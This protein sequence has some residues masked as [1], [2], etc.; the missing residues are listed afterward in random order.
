MEPIIGD[1]KLFE[2]DIRFKTTE[3]E[4][5]LETRVLSIVPFLREHFENNERRHPPKL[6]ENEESLVRSVYGPEFQYNSRDMAFWFN[7]VLGLFYME[8]A[9]IFEGKYSK[10]HISETKQAA[11]RQ[12]D[13]DLFRFQ[14]KDAREDEP[15]PSEIHWMNTSEIVATHLP[16]K[17]DPRHAKL[18]LVALLHDYV[19]DTCD[20][21]LIRAFEK[22]DNVYDLFGEEIAKGVGV[23][24]DWFKSIFPY[25]DNAFEHMKGHIGFNET[26]TLIDVVMGNIDINHPDHSQYVKRSV[27]LLKEKLERIKSESESCSVTMN[28]TPYDLIRKNLVE[29]QYGIYCQTIAEHDN[30]EGDNITVVKL[31]D[32]GHNIGTGIDLR[33]GEIYSLVRKSLSS[34]YQFIPLINKWHNPEIT[35]LFRRDLVYA[36]NLC[37]WQIRNVRQGMGPSDVT[38]LIQMGS[39]LMDFAEC[40]AP[41]YVRSREIIKDTISGERI[42]FV[43]TP[44]HYRKRF[45]FYP[46]ANQYSLPPKELEEVMPNIMTTR[47]KLERGEVD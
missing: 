31:A 37:A 12:I 24:T 3:E 21:D 18:Y 11:L 39:E 47:S 25:L 30:E 43:V 7:Q 17:I 35:R 1:K 36:L 15:I 20:N 33:K 41:D 19:E 16:L 28:Q 10:K 2:N 38:P 23:C 6:N 42:N 32:I 8:R 34:F 5:D 26:F 9:H 14:R 46:T 45:G 22:I 44:D 4:G 27:D 13:Q 40:W 29:N